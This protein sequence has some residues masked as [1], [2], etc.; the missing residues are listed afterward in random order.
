MI[1]HYHGVITIAI[2]LD[3]VDDNKSNSSDVL[4][5]TSSKQIAEFSV[6]IN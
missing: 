3:I 2:H 1:R 5:T 4:V 6:A